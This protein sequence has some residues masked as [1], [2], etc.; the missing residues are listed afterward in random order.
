METV[1]AR[2]KARDEHG[3]IGI[4]AVDDRIFVGGRLFDAQC[5]RITELEEILTLAVQSKGDW[6]NKAKEALS[7]TVRVA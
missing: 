5:N 3:D 1:T 4:V 7:K 2:V 6:R